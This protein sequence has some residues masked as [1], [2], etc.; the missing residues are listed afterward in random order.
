[1]A[2][3]AAALTGVTD[4]TTGAESATAA[5]PR[6]FLRADVESDLCGIGVNLASAVC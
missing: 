2:G 6:S 5:S 4:E 3:S 1:M